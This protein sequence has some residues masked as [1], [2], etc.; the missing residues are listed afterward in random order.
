MPR[1]DRS[2]PDG[3]GPMTGRGLGYCAGSDRPGF[4]ADEPP[5]GGAGYGRGYGARGRGRMGYGRGF[6]YGR[7]YGRG[8]AYHVPP[9]EPYDAT[10]TGDPIEPGLDLA[11]ELAS[12]KRQVQELADR[13]AGSGDAH[14]DD[15]D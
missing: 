9:V 3:M 4:M 7:G 1:G 2:G 14:K 5:R 13:L 15:S 11:A 8:R 6:G 10:T 12:L